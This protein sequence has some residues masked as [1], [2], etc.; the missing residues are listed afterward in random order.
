MFGLEPSLEKDFQK[1]LEVMARQDARIAQ[2]EAAVFELAEGKRGE[3]S[4][5]AHYQ[6][7]QGLKPFVTV[8]SLGDYNKIIH[9]GIGD[10]YK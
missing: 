10:W 3:C 1:A 8:R 2:L 4:H 5:T 7:R 6:P 9:R